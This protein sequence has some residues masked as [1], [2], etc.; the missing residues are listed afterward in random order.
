[1]TPLWDI[2]KTRNEL[3]A[4]IW[5]EHQISIWDEHLGRTYECTYVR[6][7]PLIEVGAPP[8]DPKIKSKSKVRIEG[9]MKNES[10]ST[11]LV[12]PKTVLSPTQPQ[13]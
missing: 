1:M 9:T 11:T 7:K 2:R 5:D 6:E 12:D 4:I 3:P 8:N 13:K 10:C